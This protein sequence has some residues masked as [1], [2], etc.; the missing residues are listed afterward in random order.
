MS[1]HNRKTSQLGGWGIIDM[2]FCL[3]QAIQVVCRPFGNTAPME[4]AGKMLQ[5]LAAS[6]AAMLSPW[7][8]INA[9]ITSA[10]TALGL[11]LMLLH[12]AST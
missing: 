4:L 10:R 3:W 8:Y 2:P 6:V 7:L 12:A 9:C 11:P 1:E 5:G